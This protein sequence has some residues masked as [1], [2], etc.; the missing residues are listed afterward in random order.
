MAGWLTTWSAVLLLGAPPV[1]ARLYQVAPVPAGVAAR[2]PGQARAVVLIHGLHLHPLRPGDGARAVLRSWQLPNSKLVQALAHDADV[3]A[4]CYGQTAPVSEIATLPELAN[5]LRHLR[6]MG[7]TDIVLI[8]CSAG[9]LIAR[10]VAEDDPGAGVTR[11]IQVCAPNVGTSLANL[12]SA[13]GAAPGVFVQSLTKQARLAWLA[14]RP[15]RHIPERVAFVCVVGNGL[16]FSDGVVSV[17]SQWSEDLQRQGIPAYAL[18]ADHKGVVRGERGVRLIAQ[19]ITADLTRWNAA[20]V[21]AMRKRLW[22]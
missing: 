10:Q 9:G 1:E 17:R 6:Q 5:D 8:G 4:F 20:Q 18:P 11:V 22:E 2:S 15:E 21:A 7:Y 3:F 19:L 16:L 12:K 13:A 14:E